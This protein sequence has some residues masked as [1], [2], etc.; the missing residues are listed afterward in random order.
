MH[1]CLHVLCLLKYYDV[2]VE[3][4]EEEDHRY[5]INQSP[6]LYIISM[7]DIFVY[8]VCI[9]I[10]VWIYLVMLVESKFPQFHVDN[11]II[12]YYQLCTFCF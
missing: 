1:I 7:H 8:Y 4:E 12:N 10:I 5:N 11:S 3:E 9:L 6:L 2:H